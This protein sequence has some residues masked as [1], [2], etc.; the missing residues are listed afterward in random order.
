MAS[1]SIQPFWPQQ[2]WAENCG[3]VPFWGGGAGSLIECGQGRGLPLR[4]VLSWSVQPFG[5]NTPTS[6]TDRQVRTDRT[7]ARWCRANRFANGRPIIT[8]A[9]ITCARWLGSLVVRV[10][11]SRLDGRG[12]NP[13]SRDKYED[14][15]PSSGGQTISVFHL[16][17]QA[18]SVSYPQRDGKW[19]AS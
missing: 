16:A 10:L 3:T 11:D 2:I 13:G 19:V 4:Q 5:H 1:W 14:G 7:T 17:T 15:R 12:F 6:Q 18:N 8:K 9:L